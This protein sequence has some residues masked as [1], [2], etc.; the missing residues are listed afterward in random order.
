[1]QRNRKKIVSYLK[2]T[3][4]LDMTR[5]ISPSRYVSSVICSQPFILNIR[6]P[7]FHSL[8]HSI[9]NLQYYED[10]LALWC[11]AC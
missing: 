8:S 9:N 5:D 10:S 7:V 4:Y 1:M 11:R 6:M 2:N 3:S